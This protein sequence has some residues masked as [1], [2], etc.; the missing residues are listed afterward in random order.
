MAKKSTPAQT[1]A[2]KLD[3]A[4]IHRAD[5]AARA[6]PVIF[7]AAPGQ[8]L[9]IDGW[10]SPDDPPFQE[11]IQAIYSMAFTIKMTR[12]FGGLGDYKV[13]TLEGIW[14]LP[15]GEDFSTAPKSHFIWKLL[16]RTPDFIKSSD[17]DAA[18]KAMA[19]KKK[20]VPAAARVKLESL[21]EGECVQALHVG[22][23]DAECGTIK[24][25]LEHAA[26]EGYAPVGRHHEIYLSDPRRVAP[27]RLRT[28]LRHPVA[29]PPR[30]KSKE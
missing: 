7:R 29:V 3:L 4:K 23:Y 6:K 9:A 26:A 11:A 27:E 15:P 18:R 1:V 21:D 13:S 16:I 17:L 28:I 30:G 2:D 10:G 22:S 8:Y 24:T 19:E 5:Y 25:M 12:K 14:W 20:D